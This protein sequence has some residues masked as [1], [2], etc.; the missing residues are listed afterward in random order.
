MFLLRKKFLLPLFL[1]LISFI[2]FNNSSYTQGRMGIEE[3]IKN[4][5]E[6]LSLTD[7]QV[8]KLKEIF[9]KQET[10]NQDL[11]P[12]ERRNAMRERLE[13]IDKEI[14]AILSKEQIEKYNLLKEERRKEMQNRFRNRNLIN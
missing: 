11:P 10:V 1:V 5:K 12:E 9:K 6:K 13:K 2:W 8:I 4:L 3:R 14:E 7:E